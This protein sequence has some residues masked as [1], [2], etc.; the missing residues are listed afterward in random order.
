VARVQEGSRWLV[1]VLHWFKRA[2][3]SKELKA[4]TQ[5]N[6]GISIVRKA[7]EALCG[8][9]AENAGVDEFRSGPQ[10]AKATTE[11]SL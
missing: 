2:K 8:Q 10:I 9:I 3:S 11:V 7:L 5:T 1:V 4:T 6:V